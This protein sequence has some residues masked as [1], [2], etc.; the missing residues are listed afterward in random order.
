VSLMA[1]IEGALMSWFE[2]PDYWR[3]EEGVPFDGE[4][5]AGRRGDFFHF[6]GGGQ[7]RPWWWREAACSISV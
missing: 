5:K 2:G 4:M 3:S 1:G 7:R 6:S